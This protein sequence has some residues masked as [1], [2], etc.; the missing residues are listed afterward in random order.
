MVQND[1]LGLNF[2]SFE[3][4]SDFV[5]GNFPTLQAEF[6]KIAMKL[7]QNRKFRKIGFE[8][9]TSWVALIGFSDTS[10]RV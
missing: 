10:Y 3:K 6:Q 5:L 8:V 1:E 4:I 2:F 9:K 7:D